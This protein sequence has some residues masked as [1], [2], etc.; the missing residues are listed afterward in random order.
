[1]KKGT[2]PA[3]REAMHKDAKKGPK[4][5]FGREKDGM[6]PK[7]Y[8]NAPMPVDKPLPK[9][10]PKPKSAPHPAKGKKKS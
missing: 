10:M 7:G 1:M 8:M 4:K 6:A 3:I 5:V 9:Y 2:S